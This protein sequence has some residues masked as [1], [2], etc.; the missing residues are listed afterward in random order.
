LP[1]PSEP[2]C[3][4]HFFFVIALHLRD[5]RVLAH[6]FRKTARKRSAG[7][8]ACGGLTVFV[9]AHRDRALD[10]GANARETVRKLLRSERSRTAF[11]PQPISTPPLQG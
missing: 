1:P 10:S 7:V 3:R 5:S 6:D 8:A 2:I 11:M 9:E 4:I